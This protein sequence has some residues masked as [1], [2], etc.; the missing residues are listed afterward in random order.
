MP[1]F[2]DSR[3]S[4]VSLREVE[5]VVGVSG[6]GVDGGLDG[7]LVGSVGVLADEDSDLKFGLLVV[8]LL[9]EFEQS[10]SKSLALLILLP[11]ADLADFGVVSTFESREEKFKA[12]EVVA[13]LLRVTLLGV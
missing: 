2:P 13:R 6:T 9:L 5:G 8:T 3:L 11:L 10:P 12:A 1:L 4:L 7:E